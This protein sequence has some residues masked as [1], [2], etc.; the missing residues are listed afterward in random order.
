MGLSIG[1][2]VMCIQPASRVV[3]TPPTPGEDSKVTVILSKKHVNRVDEVISQA[4]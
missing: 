4:S 1:W 3:G 2:I